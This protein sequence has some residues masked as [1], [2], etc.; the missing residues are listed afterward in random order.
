M[1]YGNAINFS[2]HSHPVFSK[3]SKALSTLL[4]GR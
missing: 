3:M 2:A 1:T 4:N